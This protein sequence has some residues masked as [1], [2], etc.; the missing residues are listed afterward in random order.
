[1][2]APRL[3]SHHFSQIF[4]HFECASARRC[5]GQRQF[6]LLELACVRRPPISCLQAPPRDVVAS[7]QA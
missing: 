6:E 3:A 5:A 4:S 2:P 1:M 7:E